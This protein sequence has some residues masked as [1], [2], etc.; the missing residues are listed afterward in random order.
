MMLVFV[1]GAAAHPSAFK[2]HAD[3]RPEK[4]QECVEVVRLTPHDRGQ[5]RTAERIVDVPGPQA[6]EEVVDVVKFFSTGTRATTDEGRRHPC[7]HR[8]TNQQTPHLQSIDIVVDI[9]VEVPRWQFIDTVGDIPV[10][11]H[12]QIPSIRTEIEA[13]QFQVRAISCEIQ[14]ERPLAGKSF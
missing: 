10:V 2:A 12:R 3:R 8:Q 13:L 1:H 14:R 5:R 7:R 6:L 9:S 11:V 4:V